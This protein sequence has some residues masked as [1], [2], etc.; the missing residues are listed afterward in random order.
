MKEELERVVSS[1]V[2]I[3]E[4]EPTEINCVGKKLRSCLDPWNLNKAIFIP[5]IPFLNIDECRA[6]STGARIFRSLDANC[7]FCKITFDEK[8]SNLCTCD[9]P[10]DRYRCLRL[11]FVIS[12]APKIFH[13]FRNEITC[14]YWRSNHL[15]WWY[16]WF[17]RKAL[18]NVI[19]TKY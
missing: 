6:K 14:R 7:G 5:H 2:I 19:W 15:Y 16:F 12:A 11:P 13:S 1:E 10:F 9:M 8:A 4:C 18:I 3:Y 17:M